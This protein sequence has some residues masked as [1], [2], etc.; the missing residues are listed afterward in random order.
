MENILI[1]SG[2]IDFKKFKYELVYLSQND[3]LLLKSFNLHF[4][5][6]LI[7]KIDI[8]DSETGINSENAEDFVCNK[9]CEILTSVDKNDKNPDKIKVNK[10]ARKEA[11]SNLFDLLNI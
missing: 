3:L 8:K 6:K 2:T 10:E 11:A 5:G 1:A 7:R 4:N 9:I